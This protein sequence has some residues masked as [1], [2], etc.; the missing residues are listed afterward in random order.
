MKILVLNYFIHH[1]NLNALKKYKNVVEIINIEDIHTKDIS[2]YNCVVSP[3]L[4]IDISNYPNTVF[5]FGPHFSVF[6][7]SKL[8]IIK[9]NKSYYNSLS[10]WVVNCW[11]QF[12]ICN[13]L[14]ICSIPFGVDTDRFT[15]LKS[16][17]ERNSVFIYYKC[18]QPHELEFI[19]Q[20]L[21]SK[22]IHYKIFSYTENYSENDYLNYLQQSKYGIWLGAHESQGFA[23]QE[24]LS[25]NVPLLV[26]N[27][28]NMNQQYG[29]N[30]PNIPAT[31]IPYWDEK[32]GEYFTQQSQFEKMYSLF[33]SKIETNAYN[34]REFILENLSIDK[35]EEKL[36]N[37]I[38]YIMNKK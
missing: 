35:C 26:W 36:I 14:N 17:K 8:N 19:K 3:S 34:P 16:I 28:T 15:E 32:C 1:K 30:Y 23:L 33:L 11:K 25:C 37:Q 4:P 2:Q 31:S 12:P 38:N 13:D 18:R 27:A 29:Y 20:F 5:I 10:S 22:N 9:G 24:A 6:P 21:N 7:D